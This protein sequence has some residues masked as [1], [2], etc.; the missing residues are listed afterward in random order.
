MKAPRSL[1]GAAILRR[2]AAWSLGSA[3]FSPFSF[4][5]TSS[6]R[7][8][9]LNVSS[10]GLTI[11]ATFPVLSKAAKALI[12]VPAK[13][14]CPASMSPESGV[15]QLYIVFQSFFF[16]ALWK[17]SKTAWGVSYF[18][19]CPRASP[20]RTTASDSTNT[21]PIRTRGFIGPSRT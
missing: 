20:A 13:T 6:V 14:S 10:M 12:I 4:F 3:G 7:P 19:A 17:A 9:F 5:S 21:P 11:S 15:R 18:F 8:C 1:I 16:A 2:I